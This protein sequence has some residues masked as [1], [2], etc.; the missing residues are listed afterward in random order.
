[1]IRAVF[2]MRM[3]QILEKY[4]SFPIVCR[5]IVLDR[6]QTRYANCFALLFRNR[7]KGRNNSSAGDH[8]H[9]TPQRGDEDHTP[10]AVLLVE[11]ET[12]ITQ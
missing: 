10:L 9:V 3:R 8:G 12:S 7:L 6:K 5:L 11:S 1:M 4:N 2:R